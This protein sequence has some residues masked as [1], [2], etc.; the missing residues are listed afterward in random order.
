M[1]STAVAAVCLGLLLAALFAS[2][3]ECAQRLD[4]GL[5]SGLVSFT[6]LCDRLT[7]FS[8]PDDGLI[9]VSVQ[10]G[11][12]FRITSGNP[13]RVARGQTASFDVEIEDG[14]RIAGLS[15]GFSLADGKIVA[16]DVKHLL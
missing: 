5:G 12:G 2:P 11:P 14:Y 6:G 10:D 16:A 7:G 4:R 3:Y 8:D 13:V 1:L 15:A 9:C